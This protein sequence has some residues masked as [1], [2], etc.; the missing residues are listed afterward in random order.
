[1]HDHLRRRFRIAAIPIDS[2]DSPSYAFASHEPVFHD[3]IILVGYLGKSRKVGEH[4]EGALAGRGF[5]RWGNE[6][7]ILSRQRKSEER[8]DGRYQKNTQYLKGFFVHKYLAKLNE[9]VFVV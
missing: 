4:N 1:M 6:S 8:Q 3:A 5:R 2:S 9:S 7:S